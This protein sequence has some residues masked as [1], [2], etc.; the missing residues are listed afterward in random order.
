M[1]NSDDSQCSHIDTLVPQEGLIGRYTTSRVGVVLLSFCH[2]ALSFDNGPVYFS[3]SLSGIGYGGSAFASSWVNFCSNSYMIRSRS[4][5]LPLRRP[6]RAGQAGDP[7]TTHS[8]A[9]WP[10][11]VYIF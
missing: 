5:L 2:R 1:T 11:K 3:G 7:T 6:N 10:L 9:Q 4:L 8:A